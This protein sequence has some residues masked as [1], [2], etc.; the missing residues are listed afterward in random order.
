MILIIFLQQLINEIDLKLVQLDRVLLN[1]T[2][3]FAKDLAEQIYSEALGGTILYIGNQKGV[4][5]QMGN[6]QELYFALGGKDTPLTRYFDM[7]ILMLH[8]RQVFKIQHALFGK[9]PENPN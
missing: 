1:D 8:N 5:K 6:I 3:Q 2:E 7:Y 4:E 9:L